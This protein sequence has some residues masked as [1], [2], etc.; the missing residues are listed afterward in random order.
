MKRLVVVLALVGASGVVWAGFRR[1]S[2][3]FCTPKFSTYWY[4]MTVSQGLISTG[5]GDQL[6][7]CPLLD[8]SKFGRGPPAPPPA[9]AMLSYVNVH[10]N[11]TNAGAGRNV[12]AFACI[13]YWGSIGSA[14]GTSSATPPG[15]GTATL[16]PGVTQW[17]TFPADFAYLEITV[18]PNCQI[19]GYFAGT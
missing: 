5:L 9:P 6:F 13:Q 17:T 11:D 14:C 18:C 15:T 2:S 8:D 10:V 1:Q 3:A 12:T 4:S 7:Y 16:T 19:Y